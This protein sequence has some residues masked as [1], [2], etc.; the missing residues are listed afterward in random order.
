MLSCAV[1]RVV[2]SASCYRYL[3]PSALVLD[4][5]SIDGRSTAVSQLLCHLPREFS[6]K[7]HEIPFRFVVDREL[8][9]ML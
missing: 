6:L 8:C 2:I 7:N 4:A 3:F 5:K 1:V 9:Q